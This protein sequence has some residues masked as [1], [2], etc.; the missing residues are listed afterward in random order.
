M[1]AKE[2][3][4]AK[5]APA[6]VK[7]KPANVSGGGSGSPQRQK[8]EKIESVSTSIEMKDVIAE[9]EM[10]QVMSNLRDV[11]Q[12]QVHYSAIKKV[13]TKGLMQG[14]ADHSFKPAKEIT[15]AE[16]AQVLAKLIIEPVQESV[17]DLKDITPD[18]WF[19]NAVQKCIDARIMVGYEDNSFRPNG[20]ITKAEI[21]VAI[22]NLQK[23]EPLG[24][25]AADKV[26]AKY[27]DNASIPNW[28]KGYI[29]A[30][31][32]K[33]MI[34]EVNDTLNVTAPLTREQMAGVLSQIIK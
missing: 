9:N 30:L 27:K 18:K 22:S 3:S 19:Y 32:D 21:L 1:V 6:A 11:A 15:R 31:I 12:E 33:G 23:I 25:E 5:V 2:E 17:K 26:L 16:A 7:E 28:A 10:D 14:Y 20:T 29:A 8:A 34:Q 24:K 4:K 13:I